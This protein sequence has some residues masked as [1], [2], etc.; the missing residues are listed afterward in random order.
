MTFLSSLFFTLAYNI[1]FWTEL[2]SGK[3]L[4]SPHSWFIIL[5]TAISI[6][7]LQWFLLL[8]FV[9]RW[10]FRWFMISLFFVTSIV[11]YFTT[12]FHIYLD[13]IMINNVLSTDYQES[14]ELLQWRII[15]YFLLLGILP[16]WII[17]HIRIYKRSLTSYWIGRFGTLFLSLFMF[18]GGAW[19]VFNDLSPLHRERKEIVYL[20]TPLNLFTSSVTAYWEKHRANA[21]RAKIIIG[22]DAH[23]RSHMK[24]SKPRVIILVVGETVRAA[25]WGLNGYRRQ[26][27]PELAK[28][29]LFNFNQVTS[30]GTSTAVS[31]PC[32]FSPYGFHAY[33]E[34]R[35]FQSESLLHLLHRIKISVLWRD[36]QSGC[37]GVCDGVPVE[38]LKDDFLCTNGRCLDEI[39]LYQLKERIAATNHDQLIVLHML[40][41]HGPAYFER[42]PKQYKV[43][44][45]ICE[46]SDLSR[47]SQ[48]AIVN[49]YDNAILYTDS[50]LARTID[51]LSTITSHDTG[52]IYVSDHGE[53]LGEYNL[54]LHGLPYVIAPDEQKKIPM[55]FWLSNGLSQQ[56]GL[57][58]DCLSAKQ[59]DQFSHDYLFST[60]LSLFDVKTDVYDRQFD[61]IY[62]CLKRS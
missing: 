50:I 8:L 38:E 56:L 28:Y 42:Y 58:E 32:M 37:K 45:P 47:C 14:K 27:T 21:N 22:G 23:Q 12:T 53:S 10:T 33:N 26:T 25:N 35:I 30:C 51:E 2:M 9:N 29:H 39:L 3:E 41:N 19:A 36:N 43:W 15:P 5:C 17:W 48:Q 46:T 57:N 7:G 31:L 59:T 24:H 60:V 1:T 16:S 18:F 52:L 34:Q 54:F 13:P 20:I 4:M 6:T 55:V 49:T 11:V 62:S 61:L 40:G 44:Q